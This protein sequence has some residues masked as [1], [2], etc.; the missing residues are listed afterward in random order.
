MLTWRGHRFFFFS[1]GYCRLFISLRP[2]LIC[3]FV[4]VW[5][6]VC[7]RYFHVCVVFGV[8]GLGEPTLLC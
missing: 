1:L 3:P 7:G 5:H 8:L 4:S 2:L 6:G